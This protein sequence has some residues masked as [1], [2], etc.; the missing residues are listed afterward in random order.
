MTDRSIDTADARLERLVGQIL[1]DRDP[2]AAPY[3]LARRVEDV[4]DEAA[5]PGRFHS[6]AGGLAGLA[7]AAVLVL[8][9]VVLAS[10]GAWR[11][12]PGVG[13]SVLGPVPGASGAGVVPYPQMGGVGVAVALLAAGLVLSG[14]LVRRR[15][16][17]RGWLLV[18]AGLGVGLGS[19]ALATLLPG[20]RATEREGTSIG[21]VVVPEMPAGFAGQ[22][23]VY[24]NADPG[25]WF[26]LSIAF[27]NAGP[28]PITV[29]GVAA[30]GGGEFAGMSP[31]WTEVL[32]DVRPDVA[33]APELEE[34]VPYTPTTLAPGERVQLRLIGAPGQCA[35]GGAFRLEDANKYSYRSMPMS[36]VWSVAGW[37][38]VTPLES[39]YQIQFPE[40]PDG[41]SEPPS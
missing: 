8:A 31:H 23:L 2:G 21:P 29:L 5:R 38:R 3:G 27:E 18:A 28:L 11:G 17:R 1:V 30:G 14:L 7:A 26:E 33:V 24:V 13:S 4:A 16:G 10:A 34:R 25:G 12:S 6:L 41:C 37:E 35:L 40:P 9:A 15:R 22:Q 20:A 36:I 39:S 32:F 19:L